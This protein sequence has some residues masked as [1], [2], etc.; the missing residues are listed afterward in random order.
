GGRRIRKK[1]NGRAQVAGQGRRQGGAEDPRAG[2]GER[3][4]GDREP[5]A[6]ARPVRGGRCR[7]GSDAGVLQGGGGGHQ[8]Y[9]QAEAAAAVISCVG[10]A[11]FGYDGTSWGWGP[12]FMHRFSGASVARSAARIREARV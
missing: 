1:N 3:H 7:P 11:A 9:L 5:A 4:S 2:Q 8:L 6:G 10:A 12:L